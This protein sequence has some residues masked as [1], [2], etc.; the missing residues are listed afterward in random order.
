MWGFHHSHQKAVSMSSGSSTLATFSDQLADIV[1]VAAQSVVSVHARPRLPSSGVHWRDGLVVTTEATVK[2]DRDITVTLPDG[3]TLP[4]TLAGRDR[5]TDLAVLSIPLGS[6]PVAR[7]GEPAR[8]RPGHLVLALARIGD[9]GPRAAFGAV[10]ATGGPWRC[11]KGGEIDRWLQSDVTLY[12]GFGGGPLVDVYGQVQG[13]NS[14]GLSRPFATTIPAATIERVAGELVSRGYV[15]RGWLGAA[16]HPVRFNPGAWERIGIDRDGGLVVLSVEPDGP[17]AQGGLLVGDVVF[18]IDGQPVE[19][20]DEVVELLT[21]AR[22]GQPLA[23]ALVRGGARAG[24]DVTVGER[25]RA[26]G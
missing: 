11:W 20:P 21:R 10:S 4:A 15:A 9:S 16:M 14:G 6:L 22:I 17:A 18:A 24:V 2:R 5:S 3:R 12:P 8:L 23:L 19:S 7:I 13:V 1:A 25:P 26:V